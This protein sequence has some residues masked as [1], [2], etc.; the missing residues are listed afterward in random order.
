[1][2]LLFQPIQFGQLTLDNKIIIA[3]MCQFSANESGELSFWHEH[4][5]ANYALSGAGLCIIK[6]TTVQPEGR[7]S[8]AD[9]GLWNGQQVL[10]IKTLLSKIQ[11]ISPMPFA[12]QLGH[13]GRKASGDT[14]WGKRKAQFKPSEKYGWQTVAPST[15][16][17]RNDEP[18]QQLCQ[19]Q[20]SSKSS[21]ILPTQLNELYR[22]VS[23]LSN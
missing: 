12:V 5:W 20:K 14:P 2:S 6:A 15:I 13:A 11:T 9:L 18:P 10:Q 1:M 22:Q 3:L 19:F 8:Y 23:N 21:E 4:Q 7:I 17:F 16:A